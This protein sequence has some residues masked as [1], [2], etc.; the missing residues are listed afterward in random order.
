MV[1]T[2]YTQMPVQTRELPARTLVLIFMMETPY[3][4]MPVQ[5]REL[6]ART[7]VLIFMMKLRVKSG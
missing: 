1:E 3:T 2:P 7:L 4:Q 6:P 5:T